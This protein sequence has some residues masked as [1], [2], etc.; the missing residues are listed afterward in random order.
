MGGI[1]GFD[2]IDI[3]CSPKTP[4][5]HLASVQETG[6][7]ANWKAEL[8]A[9]LLGLV[10]R[11]QFHPHALLPLAAPSV[12]PSYSGESWGSEGDDILCSNTG[13]GSWVIESGI[14]GARMKY[15]I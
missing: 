15:P 12:Y 11:V 13:W 14:M 9:G 8:E 10:H 6:E 1:G 7:E 3:P 2:T 4:L 5:P